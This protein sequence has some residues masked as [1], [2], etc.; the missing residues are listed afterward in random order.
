MSFVDILVTVGKGSIAVIGV[1]AKGSLSKIGA[2]FAESASLKISPSQN[3]NDLNDENR[4]YCP[5]CGTGIEHGREVCIGCK[6]DI[7][8]GKTEE[9]LEGESWIIFLFGG[10]IAFLVLVAIP[11][12][13]N[14]IFDWNIALGFGLGRYYFLFLAG[15]ITLGI[16]FLLVTCQKNMKFEQRIRCRL[17]KKNISGKEYKDRDV[18]Y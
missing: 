13:L 3:T 18:E 7:I 12:L 14:S 2:N 15:L 17:Y 8:Y 16:S 4:F 10:F 5:F 9:E 1:I 11:E 6:A